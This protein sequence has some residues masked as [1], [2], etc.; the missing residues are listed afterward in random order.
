MKLLKIFVGIGILFSAPAYAE[1][2]QCVGYA[3]I[4][5]QNRLFRRFQVS[6]RMSRLLPDLAVARCRQDFPEQARNC[7]EAFTR[8]DLS[9]PQGR[10]VCCVA[11]EFV[12]FAAVACSTK[13]GEMACSIHCD[14]SESLAR[15][16]A[17]KICSATH[18]VNENFCQVR[19]VVDLRTISQ[20]E[21]LLEVKLR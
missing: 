18:G 16:T 10:S 1:E 6:A 21:P 3:M 19:D 7:V 14:E 20:D 15:K 17:Q 4:K 5:N 13:N 11:G 2:S 9:H 8:S 12:Q